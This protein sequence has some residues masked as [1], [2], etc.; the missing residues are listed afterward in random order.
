MIVRKLGRPLELQIGGARAVILPLCNLVYVMLRRDGISSYDVMK[1]CP[2]VYSYTAMQSKAIRF[3][4]HIYTYNKAFILLL[5]RL[6]D[7]ISVVI[8]LITGIL[9]ASPFGETI[10]NIQHTALVEDM[11][12]IN[13]VSIMVDGSIA[14]TYVGLKAPLCSL[15]S[16]LEPSSSINWGKIRQTLR[17]SSMI[18]VR[19]LEQDTLVGS[20]Y[21]CD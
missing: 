3:L 10:W 7:Q 17:P 11:T 5:F 8:E 6:F 12:S 16:S 21:T 20:S 14:C 2:L 15:C 18:G 13:N 4:S 1:V 19:Q 9:H